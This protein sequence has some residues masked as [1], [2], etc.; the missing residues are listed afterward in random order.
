MASKELFQKAVQSAKVL[1][2]SVKGIHGYQNFKTD[3]AI[4]EA[5]ENYIIEY[6]NSLKDYSA[7]KLEFDSDLYHQ[8]NHVDILVY[9]NEIPYFCIDAKCL[10]CEFKKALQFTGIPSE[11]CMA[12]NVFNLLEYQKNTIPTYLF[13]YHDL[14]NPKQKTGYYI[15]NVKDIKVGNTVVQ[16]NNRYGLSSY[17]LNLDNKDFRYYESL[18]EIFH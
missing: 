17:K 11:R 12:V 16:Q 2:D 1:N 15:K 5:F 3:L 4:G 13:I 14:D 9:K 18:E 6:F 10:T 7:I 8:Y